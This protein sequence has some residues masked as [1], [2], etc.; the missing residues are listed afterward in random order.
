MQS[1]RR[2]L[3]VLPARMAVYLA[4]ADRFNGEDA[5]LVKWVRKQLGRIAVLL[6]DENLE[7]G[8]TSPGKAELLLGYLANF[9]ESN[10]QE[11]VSV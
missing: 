7:T 1:P 8:V 3:Q 4:W 10:K 2:A 6:K 5:G 11:G 9:K